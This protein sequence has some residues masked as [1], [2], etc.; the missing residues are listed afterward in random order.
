MHLAGGEL[1]SACASG[2]PAAR[3]RDLRR[4]KALAP[5]GPEFHRVVTAYLPLVYG[6]AKAFIPED[7]SAAERIAT[8]VF[9]TFAFRWKALSR[10]TV[11]ASWFLRTTFIASQRERE[12]LKLKLKPQEP[13]AAAGYWAYKSLARLNESQR[14]VFILDTILGQCNALAL[15]PAKHKKLC[16]KALKLVARQLAKRGVADGAA[17]YSRFNVIP[18]PDFVQQLQARLAGWTRNQPKEDLVKA[19]IAAWQWIGF[20]RFVRAVAKTIGTVALILVVL[21]GTFAFLAHNGY[22]TPFFLA[23][24]QKNMIKDFP[25]LGKPAQPWPVTEHDK[26]LVRRAL[27]KDSA[28]LYTLTNIWLAK[29]SFTPEQWK[30]IQPKS[31][32]PIN[33]GGNGG[34][35]NLRNPN[36]SRSGLAGVLGIDHQWTVG[37]L[38]FAGR[39]FTNVAVRYRGNGTYINS[40]YGPKQSLKVDLNKHTKG[41]KIGGVAELNFLNSIADF[42][43]VRDTLAERMFRDL[44]VPAPR[45]A[46]AYV[47]VDV[48]GKFTNQA[49]GLFVLME[50]IDGDFA[51]DRFGDKETPIFKPV[52][53]DLFLDRDNKTEL[54]TNWANYAPIYDLKTKATPPQ[55][56]RLVDLSQLTSHASDEEFAAKIADYVDLEE[57]AAFVAGHALLSSYDGFLANGQNYYVYLDPRSNKF[58]F[59]SWDQD[60]SWGE[61]PYIGTADERDKASI[62]EPSIYKNKFL[63]RVFKVEAFREHYRAKLEFALKHLFIPERLNEQIDELAAL[64]RPAVAAENS[65]RLDRFDKAVSSEWLEGP[66]DLPGQE[67]PRAPVHQIK[68]FIENRAKSVRAQLDGE[69]KGARLKSPFFGDN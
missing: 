6:S 51:K 20:G 18:S 62:W 36:A 63:E 9:E 23:M 47:S 41:Q 2:L 67:G 3:A 33:M 19:S 29:L 30:A 42:S 68:R 37:N 25:E 54:G 52:T 57:F 61:F 35:M 39:Q 7:A 66:R 64:I 10:S 50:D 26:T 11:L 34:R 40:L 15:K 21:G 14:E 1:S 12:R 44:G 43:Y 8:A 60:H 65:F 49:F 58:G 5:G 16:D 46:Y 45:T 17:I 69:E 38:E 13:E 53:Y 48:P 27:P 4:N 32:K 31:V 28:E 55:L 59:I 22:L 24:N 56:Q